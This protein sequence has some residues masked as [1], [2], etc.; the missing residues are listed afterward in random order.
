M[1]I[2][3]VGLLKND[4][5]ILISSI[6]LLREFLEHFIRCTSDLCLSFLV[7]IQLF[8]QQ[9]ILQMQRHKDD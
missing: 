4:K 1:H 7:C 6:L 3:E 2:I 8:I 9:T 5:Y